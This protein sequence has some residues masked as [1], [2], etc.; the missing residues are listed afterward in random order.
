MLHLVAVGDEHRVVLHAR[1]I[2]TY[3]DATTCRHCAEVLRPRCQLMLKIETVEMQLSL[4]VL[5]LAE[6]E[7]LANQL[8]EY[9]CVALHHLQ[10]RALHA[11]HRRVFQK[12]L[13]RS[14][15]E[16]ERRAQLVTH[17]REELQLRLRHL[18]HLCGHSVL[19]V[20]RGFQLLV[21]ARSGDEGVDSRSAHGDEQH[22]EHQ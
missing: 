11:M 8:Y 2:H 12:L 3:R 4:V 15:D 5:H 21:D 7:Y 22:H 17:V 16:R 20:H 6:V 10:H 13:R 18:L 14:G 1:H 19:L 9:A